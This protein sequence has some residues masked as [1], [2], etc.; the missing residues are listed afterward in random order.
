MAR[1]TRTRSDLLG[2]DAEIR[3]AKERARKAR[4]RED[5]RERSR[6]IDRLSKRRLPARRRQRKPADDSPLALPVAAL[7][8]G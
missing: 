7:L 4:W 6:Q 5:H 2:P 8:A 1:R 3:R